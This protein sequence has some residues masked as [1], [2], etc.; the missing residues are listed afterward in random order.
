MEKKTATPLR[1]RFIPTQQPTSSRSSLASHSFSLSTPLFT[2]MLIVASSSHGY[3]TC[4]LWFARYTDTLSVSFVPIF[5]F[6]VVGCYIIRRWSFF[7]FARRV[8]GLYWRCYRNYSKLFV[9][10]MLSLSEI[11][12]LHY[13]WHKVA[14]C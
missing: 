3:Y 9:M 1:L 7:S 11:L 4:Q 5:H 6:L 8:G 12:L 13:L 14:Y 10:L 2:L